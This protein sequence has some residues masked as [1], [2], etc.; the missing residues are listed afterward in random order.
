MNDYYCKNWFPVFSNYYFIALC[1]IKPYLDKRTNIF[2]IAIHLVNLI[3]AFFFLFFSN[4][5]KQAAVVSSVMAVILFVLNAAFALFLL[6]FTIVTCALALIHRNPDV[7]YQP[8]KDDRVSFIPKMTNGDGMTDYNNNKSEAE[9]FELRQAVLDTNETE[10]EKELRDDA[11]TK[12]TITFDEESS[13]AFDAGNNRSSDEFVQPFSVVNNSNNSNNPGQNNRS[14]LFGTSSMS[15]LLKTG[16][17]SPVKNTT[18]LNDFNSNNN[19]N[20][21]TNNNNNLKKPETSFY[22]NNHSYSRDFL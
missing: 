5:F 4:L 12:R 2:N 13:S 17:R 3:N 1:W 7:R 11:F 6:I 18:N 14:T 10:K 20:I 8:M 16:S 22:N 19:N 15:N 21:N 9:L